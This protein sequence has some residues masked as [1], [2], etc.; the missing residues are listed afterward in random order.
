MVEKYRKL[1]RSVAHPPQ[2]ASET[3]GAK[4]VAFKAE[5]IGFQPF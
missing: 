2:I 1:Q 4:P 5:P 3:N